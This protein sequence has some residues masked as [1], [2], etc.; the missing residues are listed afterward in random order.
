MKFFNLILIVLYFLAIQN[1]FGMD[2]PLVSEVALQEIAEG[3]KESIGELIFYIVARQLPKEKTIIEIRYINRALYRKCLQ[4]LENKLVF[5]KLNEERG[6]KPWSDIED[7]GGQRTYWVNK[8]FLEFLAL[9]INENGSE[10]SIEDDERLNKIRY[11]FQKSLLPKNCLVLQTVNYLV[12]ENGWFS[13]KKY[14]KPQFPRTLPESKGKD[15]E[16]AL[17]LFFIYLHKN[18]PDFAGMSFNPLCAPIEGAMGDFLRSQAELFR[19][20]RKIRDNELIPSWYS[21]NHTP[22]DDNELLFLV[23]N[24]PGITRNA[25]RNIFLYIF[26]KSNNFTFFL[27]IKNREIFLAKLSRFIFDYNMDFDIEFNLKLFQFFMENASNRLKADV[28]HV[29]ACSKIKN[30]KGG[31]LSF[32]DFEDRSAEHKRAQQLFEELGDLEK[33]AFHAELYRTHQKRAE[34][35]NGARKRLGWLFPEGNG[36]ASLARHL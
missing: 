22:I 28:L 5:N 24:D 32:Y 16:K 10:W 1:S 2:R 23:I 11:R 27:D 6:Y 13:K 8:N 25:L 29:F 21:F 33:A 31:Y 3:E 36:E 30:L 14:L 12:A 35:I 18:E 4:I 15:N 20:K 19:I 9:K 7:I 34:E 26:Y 17:L